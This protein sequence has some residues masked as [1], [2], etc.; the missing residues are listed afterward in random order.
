MKALKLHH[1]CLIVCFILEVGVVG[2]G[3]DYAKIFEC[4]IVITHISF[5]YYDYSND[6]MSCI[7]CINLRPK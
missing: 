5:Q 7:I 6:V 2:H 3:R 1:D 4:R